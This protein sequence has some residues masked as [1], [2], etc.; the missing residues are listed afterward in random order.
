MKNFSKLLFLLLAV[1]IASCSKN[2]K[3]E[4]VPLRDYA[5]QYTADLDSI[6]KFIDTHYM[7]VTPELDVTF[8]KIDASAQPSIRQQSDFPL[9]FKTVTQGTIDYKV[10]YI[11]FREGANRQPTKLDSVYVT[12]KGELLSGTSFDQAQTP[13]WFELDKVVK[14]W[15]EIVPM[16]KTGFYD[17]S[18]DQSNPTSFTDFGAGVMFLPSALGYYGSTSQSGSIP[19]YSPLIFSFKLMELRYTDHDGDGIL[20]KD[21]VANPGDD[22]ELYDTDGDGTP[23]YRDVDDDGDG[24]LTKFEIRENGVI[25]FPTCPGGTISK[26]LDP[27]CH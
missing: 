21:E 1:A 8:A 5:L 26:H 10:Y 25:T 11:N 27:T 16:F 24:Y 17:N 4:T 13:I 6:N 20:S 7:T 15:P 14:G 22:P 18:G 12:Y 19:L 2:D 23:N 9:Q 3:I